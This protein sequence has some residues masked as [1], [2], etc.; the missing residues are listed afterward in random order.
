MLSLEFLFLV[1]VDVEIGPRYRKI[2][3]F[4]TILTPFSMGFRAFYEVARLWASSPSVG[5]L[6]LSLQYKS[7]NTV[8]PSPFS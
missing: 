1:N 8:I 6:V 7:H 2:V 3:N 4:N 5:Y